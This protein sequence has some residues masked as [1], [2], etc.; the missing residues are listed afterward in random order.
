M[1]TSHVCRSLALLTAFL[2]LPLS[3]AAAAPF[4]VVLNAQGEFLDAYLIDGNPV[5]KRVVFIDPDPPD[6]Q[7]LKTR[8]RVGRHVNGR[9]CFF[10]KGFGPKG[11]FVIADDTYREACLDIGTPQARCAITNP[12]DPQYVGK[13]PDGWGVFK[14]SGKWAKWQIHAEHDFSLPGESQGTIDPQG[15][16]FDAQ[17]NLWG[18]DVG[19]GAFGADDGSLIVFFPGP[20]KR[21]DTYCFVD[22]TLAAPSMP[23]ADAFGNI[24]LSETA[25]ARI[26]KFSPPFP[27][28]AAD[29]A[30]PGHLVTIPPTKTV[31]APDSGLGT[32]SGITHVR[33]TDRFLIASVLIPAVINEYS[34]TGAFVR[35]IV[36]A[37]VPK[38]PL[39]IDTGTDGTVYYSE[40][41]LDPVTFDTRCG[42]VSRARF[43]TNGQPLPPEELGRH[44]RFPD[45]VTVVSSKSLKVKWSKLPLSPDIDPS[46][47]GGE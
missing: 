11:G 21:Y 33:G 42:S 22:K 26:T 14:K 35:N 41:N 39:G 10:P 17:G 9:L 27:S 29:C 36:P 25:G 28:S 30:N 2:A 34:A 43:D 5:P 8:A 46:R 18:N 6:P 19:H 40:L 12:R 24:Y 44:L 16:L 23:V 13:D 1:K 31:F 20:K 38:N 3:L 37:G 45:G 7:D 15:C 47:C 4:D 32:P